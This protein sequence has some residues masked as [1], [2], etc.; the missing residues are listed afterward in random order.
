M[1]F[2]SEQ[3]LSRQAACRSFL[4]GGN[5]CLGSTQQ[6]C[7]SEKGLSQHVMKGMTVKEIDWEGNR[8]TYPKLVIPVSSLQIYR[9]PTTI[10]PRQSY[11]SGGSG[12]FV[13]GSE[14]AQRKF[15][16]RLGKGEGWWGTLKVS[17]V[18]RGGACDRYF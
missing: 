13:N 15:K 12:G 3:Y 2:I 14:V 5:I 1:P 16:E 8:H 4:G 6:G 18:M 9:P 17:R 11:N 7:L 10:A